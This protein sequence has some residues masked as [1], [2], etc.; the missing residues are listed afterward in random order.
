[1]RMLLSV[2]KSFSHACRH[3]LFTSSVMRVDDFLRSKD[4]ALIDSLVC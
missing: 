4:V 2:D 3:P 1:M